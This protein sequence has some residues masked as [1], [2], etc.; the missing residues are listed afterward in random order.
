MTV[1]RVSV[2][3]LVL[4]AALVWAVVAWGWVARLSHVVASPAA[5]LRNPSGFPTAIVVHHTATPP[6]VDGRP[7]DVAFIDSTHAARGFRP[8]TGPDGRVYHIGYHYLIRQDGTVLPARPE[9]L[10]GMH[11][12]GHPEMLG[13]CLIGDYDNS[14]NPRGAHGPNRPPKAQLDAAIRLT[15]ELM[16]R[17]NLPAPR[18][19]LHR[20]L[21]N[22]LCPGGNFPVNQF[23]AGI[24]PQR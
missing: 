7:V 8:V 9:S 12:R 21:T 16:A 17:H 13:V 1:Y 15:G 3:A 19:F 18:V 14:T 20:E 24:A 6:V 5:L 11:T 4:L 22:T 10:P 23:R 2:A